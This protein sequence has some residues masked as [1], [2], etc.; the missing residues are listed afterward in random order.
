MLEREAFRSVLKTLA[1]VLAAHIRT[2]FLASDW[3]LPLTDVERC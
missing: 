3:L 1:E 2:P